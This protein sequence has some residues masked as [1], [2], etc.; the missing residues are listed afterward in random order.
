MC[1]RVAARQRYNRY[2]V[3]SFIACVLPIVWIS[4]EILNIVPSLATSNKNDHVTNTSI[5]R[6]E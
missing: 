2:T 5:I 1:Y 3:D 6:M 4:A